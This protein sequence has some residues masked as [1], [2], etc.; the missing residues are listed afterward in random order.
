MLKVFARRAAELSVPLPWASA[1]PKPAA[2][3]QAQHRLVCV[4]LARRMPLRT[5]AGAEL[6]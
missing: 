1:L 5:C 3:A 2:R 4:R 6:I